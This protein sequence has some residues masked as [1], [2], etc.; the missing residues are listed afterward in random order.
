MKD[1]VSGYFFP[2]HDG[3]NRRSGRTFRAALAVASISRVWETVAERRRREPGFSRSIA[4]NVAS[5]TLSIDLVDQ[6]S[7][8]VAIGR[9]VAG[10]DIVTEF[11]I[12]KHCGCRP[13]IVISQQKSASSVTV[14]LHSNELEVL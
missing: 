9:R 13:R 11:H 10:F 2:L 3:G 7:F 1:L 4:H 12:V 6:L 8:N 5:D 14:K